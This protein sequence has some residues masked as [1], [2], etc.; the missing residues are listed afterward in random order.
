[1]LTTH[2]GHVNLATPGSSGSKQRVNGDWGFNASG[3][4]VSR[5]RGEH[6]AIVPRDRRLQLFKATVM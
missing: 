6:I 2:R 3:R 1:M 5:A 4:R